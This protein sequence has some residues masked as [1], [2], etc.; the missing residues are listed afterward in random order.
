MIRRAS[1]ADELRHAERRAQRPFGLRG[2]LGGGGF[3]GTG[4]E[5]PVTIPNLAF[6]LDGRAAAFSDTGGT[7]P[8]VAPSGRVRRVNQADAIAGPPFLASSDA[9]RSFKELN[10]FGIQCGTSSLGLSMPAGVTLP[11]TGQTLAGCFVNTAGYGVMCILSGTNGNYFGLQ[12]SNNSFAGFSDGGWDSG[13]PV[14]LGSKVAW[15]VRTN[16]AGQ[17]IMLN[18]DGAVLTNTQAHAISGV[19]SA[20][21]TG[22]STGVAA[23]SNSLCGQ[24]LG[25]SRRLTDAERTSLMGF[26][27]KR[28]APIAVPL[29][30]PLFAIA[31]DSIGEGEV[32]STTN[33]TWAARSIGNT[34]ANPTPAF[35]WNASIPGDTIQTQIAIYMAKTRAVVRAPGRTKNAVVIVQVMSNSILDQS[36]LTA[37][38]I[39]T[40][41]YDFC[42]QIRAD[43]GKAALWTCLPRSD[44]AAGGGFPARRTAVNDDIKL[45]GLAHADVLIDTTTIA[46][47]SSI[48]DASGA[49]FNADHVHPNDSGHAKIATLTNTQ[50]APFLV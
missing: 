50:L 44:A 7:V 36:G 6:W 27:V 12:L 18:V 33:L 30:A 35:L 15:C 3:G 10:A 49:D 26:L 48:A 45:N 29:D 40:L 38:Q 22:Y 13:L 28:V 43:G 17:D 41:L 8:A 1:F 19:V 20:M 24:M 11:N 39:L 4:P 37:G 47:M 21:S 16:A 42:A 2:P 25:Y 23:T 9:V 32:T 14:P 46:G 31:G 5:V 34:W